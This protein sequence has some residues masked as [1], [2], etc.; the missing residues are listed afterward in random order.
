MVDFSFPAVDSF[1]KFPENKVL[2]VFDFGDYDVL[3]DIITVIS[4]KV[5]K[6]SILHY[7]V[8]KLLKLDLVKAI[9]NSEGKMRK[10]QKCR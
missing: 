5:N 9:E 10:F 8:L 4:S 6:K 7:L 3:D 2:Y 1:I